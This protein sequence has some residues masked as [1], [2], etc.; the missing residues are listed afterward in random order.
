MT[1]QLSASALVVVSIICAFWS[2]T[3]I[4][5][6][7]DFGVAIHFDA[8]H[9]IFFGFCQELRRNLKFEIVCTIGHFGSS[10]SVVLQPNFSLNPTKGAISILRAAFRRRCTSRCG[11]S[12]AKLRT[13]TPPSGVSDRLDSGRTRL[14][15][16]AIH[17]WQAPEKACLF[18]CV[19]I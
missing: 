19:S 11:S 3:A 14:N 4:V 9:Q 12:Y 8:F 10:P 5:S 16:G 15:C 18:E 17:F 13:T 1:T 2:T 6:L 7:E